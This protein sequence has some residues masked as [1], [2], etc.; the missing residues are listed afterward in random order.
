[1]RRFMLHF[2]PHLSERRDD[3]MRQLDLSLTDLGVPFERTLR[4]RAVD[5]QHLSDVCRA[6]LEDPPRLLD[7]AIV[8]VLKKLN[9]SYLEVRSSRIKSAERKRPAPVGSGGPVSISDFVVLTR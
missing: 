6:V 5:L 7:R 8:F 3:V 4:A 2:Y 9:D 1:V